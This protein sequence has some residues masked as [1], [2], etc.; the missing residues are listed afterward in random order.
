MDDPRGVRHLLA[1]CLEGLPSDLPAEATCILQARALSR[2]ANNGIQQNM[3]KEDLNL[4][5]VIQDGD[6]LGSASTNR[7]GPEDLRRLQRT[8]LAAARAGAPEKGLQPLR[9][10]CPTPTH[11]H[12]DAATGD[13]SPRAKAE[14]LAGTFALARA[15]GVESSGIF[16]TSLNELGRANSA[17]L[18]CHGRSTEAVFSTTFQTASGSGWAEQRDHR[19]SA[20]D[21]EGLS[22]RAAEICRRAQNPAPVQPGRYTVVLPPAAVVDFV[23]YLGWV[24][25][26]ARS[27]LDGTSGLAGKRGQAVFG[28]NMT[29]REDHS[30][31]LLCSLPFD[32]E[33][34][35]RR[36]LTLVEQGVFRQPVFDLRTAAEAGEQSTGHGHSRPNGS[37]PYPQNLVLEG[38]DQSLEQLIADTPDGLLVTHFHYTNLVDPM[39]LTLTGMTR[40]GVFRI[41]DG[42][43][44]EPVH[45]LR[46]TVS[47]FD[48]FRNIDG[49]GRELHLAAR[50][51]GGG[52][53]V[54]ALRVRDFNFSS[55]S[56]F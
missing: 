48:L 38:G 47:L 23:L 5:L 6:R 51:F 13:H 41:R 27:V 12:T 20:L 46:Y 49:L 1:A 18:F 56:S 22:R 14:A 7:T 35:S 36:P 4:H 34:V 24:A 26:G 3:A 15:E 53:V 40:D 50:G 2:F 10:S 25:L 28:S 43:V 33:G 30:H 16:S 45:N 8:A 11:E 17:G 55:V 21:P 44:A 32:M 9:A 54:P 37:G 31:P 39:S 19:V 52:A 29:L 42:Q